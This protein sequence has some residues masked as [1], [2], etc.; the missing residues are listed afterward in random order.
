VEA[1]PTFSISVHFASLTDP[2][3]DRSKLHSLHDILVIAFSAIIAGCEGWAEVEDFARER[4][5]WYRSFL[6]LPNGIPSHDTLGRV[7]SLLDPAEF[8]R[9]FAAWAQDAARAVDGEV[10]AI[11]GKTARRSFDSATKKSPVHMVSAWAAGRQL[12][13]GQIATEEKSNEITAIPKLLKLLCVQGCVV[14]VDA[15]GAQKKIAE[16]IVEGGG[17]YLF[18]LKGNQPTLQQEVQ[19]FFE[20][21]VA[22]GWKG[23]PNEH[24]E[25][26]DKGH[27]RIERRRCWCSS[28]VAWFEDR[29]Q[30]CGLR[31][32]VMVEEE[33]S[34]GAKTSRETRYFLSSLDGK[35]ARRT[36]EA[37][38]AHWSIENCLH[39]SLDVTFAEDESRI[40]KDHAPANAAMLRRMALN[41]LKSVRGDK[42]SLKIRTKMC[43]WSPDYHLKVLMGSRD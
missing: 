39:W 23:V 2:R 18:A 20:S 37:V 25:S 17:D 19:D 21:A 40:R 29:K 1:E 13:L 24:A 38:R 32:F 27:G 15:I 42:R 36:L 14:T 4:E 43:G 35:D 22:E 6:N 7:F 26:T 28:D 31:S 30:W 34:V 5:D 41:A 10:I 12:V 33:R 8:A 11:D 9:C 16:A 3:L